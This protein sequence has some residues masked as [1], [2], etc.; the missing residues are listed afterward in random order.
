MAEYF[1]YR[2]WTGRTYTFITVINFHDKQLMMQDTVLT[3]HWQ[4]LPSHLPPENT[5]YVPD[6]G[7]YGELSVPLTVLICT[8]LFHKKE[9]VV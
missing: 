2:L 9:S 3:L 8:L 1:M 7:S 5:E 4:A 6:L